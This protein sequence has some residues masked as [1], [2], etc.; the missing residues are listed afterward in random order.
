MNYT[1]NDNVCGLCYNDLPTLIISYSC[2]PEIWLSYNISIVLY[3]YC[4]L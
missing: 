4:T 1:W 3:L 2:A